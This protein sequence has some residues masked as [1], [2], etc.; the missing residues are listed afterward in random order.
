LRWPSKPWP[1]FGIVAGQ[2][3]LRRGQEGAGV[4]VH[5][6]GALDQEIHEVVGLYQREGD[7]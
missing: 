1:P 6:S 4:G 2:E 3:K 7:C 5:V